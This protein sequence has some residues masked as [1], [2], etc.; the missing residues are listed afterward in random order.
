MPA[1]LRVPLQLVMGTRST[2][3]R[4]SWGPRCSTNSD[5]LEIWLARDRNEDRSEDWRPDRLLTGLLAEDGGY[6]APALG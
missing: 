6:L 1:L 5:D 4:C 3:A 2:D